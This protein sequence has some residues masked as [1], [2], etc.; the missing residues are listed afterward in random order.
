MNYALLLSGGIGSRTG[1]DMPKQYIRA[2]SYMMTTYAVKSLVLS[3]NIDAVYIVAETDRRDE[4]LSDIGSAGLD[5]SKIKG[6]AHPGKNRQ[7]SIFNGMEQILVENKS[8][9]DRNISDETKVG[10]GNDESKDTILIHDAARPFLTEELLENMYRALEDHDGVMPYLPMKDTV[11]ESYDGRKISRLLDRKRIYAG[12]A[13]EL[14]R[15]KAYYK[16]NM[17]LMPDKIYGINGASEPAVLAG[18][19]IV[20]IPGDEKNFKV[21]TAEDLKKFKE[22][23]EIML[24]NTG[25]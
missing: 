14:F 9:E 19:D 6:V 24:M 20:M 22:I 25:I 4:I 15:L 23:E 17:A 16:A 12:Q 2:G 5:L 21:T 3:K 7:L 1:A 10:A 8:K 18:M 11:Y 13:P